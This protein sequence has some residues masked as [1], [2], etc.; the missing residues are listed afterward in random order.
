[1]CD[2]AKAP[3]VIEADAFK[4]ALEVKAIEFLKKRGDVYQKV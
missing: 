4:K 2:F 1:L 3:G